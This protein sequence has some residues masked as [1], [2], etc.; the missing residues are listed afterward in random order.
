MKNWFLIKV[1][2][3]FFIYLFNYLAH[4]HDKLLSNTNKIQNSI[5]WS[6]RQSSRCSCHQNRKL[7][8]QMTG[9]WWWKSFL[10]VR[11]N[12]D[13]C[14]KHQWEQKIADVK[15]LEPAAP[16]QLILIEWIIK[17]ILKHCASCLSNPPDTH[18][19]WNLQVNE[20]R[21]WGPFG[22]GG[23]PLVVVG[24]NR[25]VLGTSAKWVGPDSVIQDSRAADFIR[26]THSL[27]TPSS[28]RSANTH[29][30]ICWLHTRCFR[31]R[32]R[33]LTTGRKS[34]IRRALNRGH[35]ETSWSRKC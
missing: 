26:L 30:F 5:W 11:R 13:G 17:T 18:H 27:R 8:L 12:T 24:E 23:C 19:F 28:H 7:H 9:S 33:R 16:R 34:R 2:R 14:E 4:D 15:Q 31:R 29:T 3:G 21:N 1:S 32:L 25:S 6:V 35:K 10:A 22:G 20:Q